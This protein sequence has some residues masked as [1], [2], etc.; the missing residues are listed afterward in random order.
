MTNDNLAKKIKIF[1]TT[2]RDGE[3]SP[4]ASMNAFEK[5][6]IA[7][8]LAKLNVD[9]IEAGFAV[10]SNDDFEAVKKIA[11]EIKG[12]VICSLA[13][14]VKEDIDRAWEAV[15]YSNN[16]R[17]HVFIATS[18]IHIEKKLKMS[19]EKVISN[20]KD[21]VSYAKSLCNDIEFSAED[22]SRTDFDF[23]ILALKTAII[24]GA[25]T[26]NIPDT[27]GYAQ[28]QEFGKRIKKIIKELKDLID[29][30]NITV[31]VHCHD[32]LGNAVANSLS[33]IK[34]GAT[35]VEGCINGIGERAGNCAIEEL[36]MNLETRKNY[37][38]C[39]TE[40]NLKEIFLTSKLVS[41]ITGLNLSRNK[42]IV[43]RN[44]FSHEAGI[45]QHGMFADKNTYEIMNKES[46]GWIGE[47]IVIGKHSGKHAIKE[48][49]TKSGYN[50]TEPILNEINL[51]VK[52]LADLKKQITNESIIEMANNSI[53]N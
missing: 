9:I 1:D 8:Q 32:D 24:A 44:A 42:A 40:I 48:I 47:S 13:R 12:P 36:I 16:P 39:C 20:I 3:Q 11:M 33:G 19:N 4:G 41:E 5:L 21:M 23:M 6:E 28:P 25:S 53:K 37:Y 51:K 34:N 50:I 14:L 22:A 35:Q 26:I 46:I 15:K 17:I 49:L 10:S 38:N 31:S 7:R 18:K 52:N 2:L 43:G 30:K 29:K 27:V 45:H